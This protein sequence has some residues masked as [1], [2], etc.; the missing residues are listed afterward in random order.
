MNNLKL[1]AALLLGLAL[2]S[3]A[4]AAVEL[5]D[6]SDLTGT[7]AASDFGFVDPTGVF[8]DEPFEDAALE[9]GFD[10]GVFESDFSGPDYDSVILGDVGYT[11]TADTLVVDEPFIDGVEPGVQT[12]ECTVVD[13]D[14]FTLRSDDI[15]YDFND[16]G[17]YEDGVFEGTFGVL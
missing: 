10:A 11:A 5:S 12:F 9:V 15:G 2:S 16:D 8:E 1:S 3:C 14:T 13:D 7:Y 17:V 4:P 6:C